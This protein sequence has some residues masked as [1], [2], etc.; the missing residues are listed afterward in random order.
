M[1]NSKVVKDDVRTHKN[2]S[3]TFVKRSSSFY[4]E[5]T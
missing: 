3:D 1:K 5:D 2:D 4:N